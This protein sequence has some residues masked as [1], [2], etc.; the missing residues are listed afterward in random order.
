MVNGLV[1]VPDGALTNCWFHMWN[2]VYLDDRWVSV[3][4]TR[5]SDR[6]KWSRYI[7]IADSSLSD[8][9]DQGFLLAG[10]VLLGDLSVFCR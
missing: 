10:M 8:E 6:V 5:A 7:K 1:A 9:N 3:D 4:A 2:E